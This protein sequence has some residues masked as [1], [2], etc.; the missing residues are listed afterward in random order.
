MTVALLGL[1]LL[2]GCSSGKRALSGANARGGVAR[3]LSGSCLSEVFAQRATPR[4]LR[5]PLQASVLASFAIFRRAAL[6]RDEPRAEEPAGDTLASQLYTHY[7]LASY[8]PAY[9]RRLTRFAG[10]RYFVVPGFAQVNKARAECLG[11]ALH[12]DR[13]TL[14]QQ[15]NRRAVESLYCLIEVPEERGASVGCEPFAGIDQ[16][17]PVFGASDFLRTPIVE[18]VPDGVAAVRI[19]YRERAPLVVAVRENAFAFTPPPPPSSLGAALRRLQAQLVASKFTE[20]TAVHWNEA[21]LATDPTKIEWLNGAKRLLRTI[22]PPTRKNSEATSIGG[23]RA[24]IG[25]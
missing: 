4:A 16:S 11:H 10:R 8:Y 22:E 13:A 5:L 7:E 19:T 9:V 21:L 24:P 23:T 12:L 14:L 20:P 25:G 15:Q 1:V 6:R 18:L 3:T 17:A 2:G